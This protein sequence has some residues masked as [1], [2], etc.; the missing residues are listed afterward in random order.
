MS[1]FSFSTTPVIRRS[2]SRFDLSHSHLTSFNVG[3]L[4]PILVQEVYPGDSFKIRTDYVARVTSSFLKPVMD[5]LYLDIMYFFCPHRL[6]FDQWQ[7]VM[8]E[9]Q[10]GA[11]APS[12]YPV[13][14]SVAYGSGSLV[15]AKTLLDYLGIPPGVAPGDSSRVPVSLLYPREYALIWNDWYRNEN[16]ENP[17]SIVKGG[18]GS[19]EFANSNPWSPTNYTGLPAYV[20]KFKDYFTTSLPSPQKGSP[21]EFNFGSVAPID[22]VAGA[23]ATPFASGQPLSFLTNPAL[24][25]GSNVNLTLVGS[26]STSIGNTV[27]TASPL[28]GDPT[29]F[30]FIRGSNLVA[31]LSSATGFNVNDV[32]MAFQTQRLLERDAREG[33]RYIEY[34]RSA[35]GV[36]AGDY[37]LQRPEFLGGS[38]NPIQIQQVAQTSAST[39]NSPLADLAAYSLSNGSAR[40]NKGFV[41]HGAIF[42]LACIR[43]KHT[44]QQ[45]I[46]KFWTRRSRVD[47]Y[48]PVFSH[49]GEQPV[50]R[51]EIFAG[52]GGDFETVFGYQEAWA[53][54]RYRPSRVSGEMRSSYA[55]S[56]DIWHFADEYS[57]S[58]VL[59]QQFLQETPDYVDRTLSVPSE[60]TN[61]FIFDFHFKIDAVRPL[62]VRSIPG[63]I[64][65]F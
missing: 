38:R 33:T 55:Q 22:T 43:Q 58:P 59:G 61:Q 20:N 16:S 28:A 49:I 1:K 50:M 35:F 42:A 17:M 60:T 30:D 3:Q 65:H 24:A 15:V 25:G 13:V 37:R 39:E 62:P 48:D 36:E 18:L 4:I 19:Y 47:F 52:N 45:G 7:A 41:E 27:R 64:D 32:R 6:V 12:S 9:N 10:N 34:I 23:S 54:L 51:S 57:V 8:G 53:D 46:E 31:D 40:M 11:W 56:L 5:N 44:Y 2:R 29:E 26:G 14:P 21:V 63:W